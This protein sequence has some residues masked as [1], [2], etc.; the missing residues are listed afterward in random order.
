[1]FLMGDEVRRT[2]H[3]NNNAYCQDNEGT[4][5]DWSLVKK[6]CGRPSFCEIAYCEARIAAHK[7][8]TPADDLDPFDQRG[9]KGWHAVKLHQ[10]DWSDRSHSIAFS[11]E[12]AKE[13]ILMFAI[14]NA[15]WE[16]LEFELPRCTVR[17]AGRNGVGLTPTLSPQDITE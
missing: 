6:T 17:R 1:M 2:Q 10:P 4:W 11:A 14:F 15:Y 13:D 16:P 5:F 7:R 9:F 12:L 3:G 8:R